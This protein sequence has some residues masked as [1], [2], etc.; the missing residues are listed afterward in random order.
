VKD[1]YSYSDQALC[2]VLFERLELLRVERNITQQ[3]IAEEIGVT[4]K[5]Y[6]NLATGNTKVS[7]LI[8]ALR[9]IGYLE[10]VDDFL[11]KNSISPIQM[12]K[13]QGKVRKNAYPKKSKPSDDKGEL[14]W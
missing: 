6:R 8:G 14:D 10:L 7:V 2:E 3:E 4:P 12:A 5:T 9:A 13:L 11:P 1:I